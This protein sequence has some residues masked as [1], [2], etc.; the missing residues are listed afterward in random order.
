M[1]VAIGCDHGGINLKNAVI[2]AIKETGNE[3]VDY[4]TYSTESVDYPVYA[5]EVATAVADGL[6]DRGVLLCGTGIGMSIVANKVRGIRC[7]HV[8]DVD[9]ARLTREHNNANMIAMGGRITDEATAKEI[10]KTFLTTDFLGGRHQRRVDMI[11]N[12]DKDR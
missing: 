2:E 9:C 11:D 7:G 5:M 4:G 8:T 12:L 3:Y 1:K 6:A 10:V